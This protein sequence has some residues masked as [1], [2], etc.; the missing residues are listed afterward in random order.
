MN[1]GIYAFLNLINEKIY[2]GSTKDFY[3][4]YHIHMSMLRGNYHDNDY[5]QKAWNKYGQSNFI[6]VILENVENNLELEQ[7]EQYWIDLTKCYDKSL[8]YNSRLKA[9][10]NSGFK[11]TQETKNNISKAKLGTKASAETKSKLSKF[12]TNRHARLRAINRDRLSKGLPML[13]T[14]DSF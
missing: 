10:N 13:K 4:R 2:L 3:K 5:F 1:G 6:F 9:N 11:L 12:H 8:G 7:R 14:T